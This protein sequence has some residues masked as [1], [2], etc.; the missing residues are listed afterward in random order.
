M[1]D[2]FRG[3]GAARIGAMAGV[4][5][6]LTGFFLYI[7]GAIT[8]PPKTILF[9]GLDSRDAIAVTTKLDAMSIPYEARGDGST[10]LIAA[11]KVSK[12]RMQLASEGMPSAGVGYEIFD[13]TD[14]F[15]ATTFVQNINKLRALEGEMSRTI[16]SLDAIAEA[17]VHLVIPER[18]VFSRDNQPPSASV[19]IKTR[20]DKLSRGQVAAIQHLVAAAVQGLTP[21]AV[22]I[23]DEKGNLL[24]GGTNG[25]SD[26]D[27]ASSS[28]EERA[29][30]Y[31]DRLRERVESMVASIVG[32]GHVRAQISAQL[33][34][35]RV[36]QSNET[37]DPDS[38]VIRSSQ[39]VEQTSQDKKAGSSSAV[40]VSS[41]LPEA[42]TGGGG[43]DNS[44]ASNRTE[45]T[46]NYEIS[47]KVTTEVQEA[48]QVKNLSVAVVVDGAYATGADGAR[49]YSPR[50]AEDMAKIT[51]LV[52]SAIGYDEKRGDKVSVTNM[53]F[54][55]ID[56]GPQEP[57]A[58]PLLGIDSAVWLKLGEI[59]ILSI[60]AL[61]V[62]LL[63]VKPMIRRLTTPLT[64]TAPAPG[65]QALAYA[66][67]AGQQQAQIAVRRQR[68]WPRIE[69][70]I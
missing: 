38:K 17:R 52:K 9:S 49:S 14:T 21:N 18:Q 4:A 2:F 8:E 3:I 11:D 40:S 39:T 12:T 13:K 57:E 48:G 59:L 54:A 16:R 20:G 43:S 42:Q 36:T 37:Y 44:S 55:P 15:G 34:I 63:V 23:V 47:K 32:L 22:A 5:A 56:M 28:Q 35:S 19:M 10:I 25:S 1:P 51:E 31:E 68:L 45:E 46:V 62:A 67:D 66:G 6:A 30:T 60:T 70:V 53:A 7:A 64:G 50:S 26:T 58:K 24:A 41:A 27:A 65:Q 69:V 29:T 61:L 33:D